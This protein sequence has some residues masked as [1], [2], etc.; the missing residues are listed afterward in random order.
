MLIYLYLSK[1]PQIATSNYKNYN[2]NSLILFEIPIKDLK[3]I[4]DDIVSN[5]MCWDV[6]NNFCKGVFRIPYS[7]IAIS[8][9]VDMLNG[10]YII[11][12]NK[13]FIASDFI[14]EK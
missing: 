5:D 2:C 3:H 14:S 10:E 8:K 11:N 9:D 4:Y 1:L 6:F 12:F 13:V 7:F